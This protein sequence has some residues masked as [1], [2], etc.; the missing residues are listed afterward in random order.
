VNFKE[1]NMEIGFKCYDKLSKLVVDVLDIDFQNKE[2]WISPKGTDAEKFLSLGNGKF[3]SGLKRRSSE[4][5]L[6]PMACLKDKFGN[7]LYHGCVI[8]TEQLDHTLLLDTW[9]DTDF[10]LA[11]VEV[12]TVRGVSFLCHS[13]GTVWDYENPDSVYYIGY[14]KKIGYIYQ[15]PELAESGGK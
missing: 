5:A 14:C 1:K 6:L 13:D 15:M 8:A 11:V 10:G 3:A 7:D 2:F 4:I 12:D 9:T